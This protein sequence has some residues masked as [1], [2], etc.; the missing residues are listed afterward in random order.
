MS[1]WRFWFVRHGET[2]YNRRG[3]RCGGD[4]DIPLT[5]RGEQQSEA[6]S[7]QLTHLGL[8][9]I[10]SSPLIR[11]RQTSAIIARCI[12]CPVQIHPLLQERLLGDWNGMAISETEALLQGGMTPPGGESEP[13]FF[14]RIG[15][16]LTELAPQMQERRIL[17]VSSK[18]VARM[19]DRLT[20]QR[21]GTAE[22][23][24]VREYVLAGCRNLPSAG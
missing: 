20:K 4:V 22:N 13:D 21:G 11:A 23:A 3:V 12:G 14:R 1:Q 16:A 6:V 17:I 18:G 15:T 8:D 5:R 19:L 24:V 9:L 10:V 7:S 2:E